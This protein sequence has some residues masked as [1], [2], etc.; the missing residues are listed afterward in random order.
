MLKYENE[1]VGCKSVGLPCMGD[2]CP[3]RNVPRY[4][5]DECGCEDTLYEFDDKEICCEC[6]LSKFNVVEGSKG[7]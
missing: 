3:N 5:C 2:S 4:Y 7:L 1:C 6:L